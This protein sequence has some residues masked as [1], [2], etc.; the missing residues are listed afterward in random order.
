MFSPGYM[1]GGLQL[2]SG[3]FALLI[4][5]LVFSKDRT[6]LLNQLMGLSLVGFAS[7]L[8]SESLI[9]IFQVEEFFYSNLLRDISN[10]SGNIAALVLLL[11]GLSVRYGNDY[12]RQNPIPIAL[13]IL[14]TSVIM[15]VG[16]LSDHVV[17][18]EFQG[19]RYLE[20]QGDFVSVVLMLIIP[21]IEIVGGILLFGNTYR[22]V[23]GSDF[24]VA[25]KILLLVVGLLALLS[26]VLWF[27]VVR[28]VFTQETIPLMALIPGH[29]GYIIALTFAYLSFRKGKAGS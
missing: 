2:F 6:Y 12:F 28:T 25:R 8:I 13:L 7:M 23:S 16:P 5:L 11:A 29:V 21:G 17:I 27:A 14:I 10:V 1:Y 26:A 24:E 18:N 22:E 20:F 3:S 19:E 4:G 15:L 9:Y